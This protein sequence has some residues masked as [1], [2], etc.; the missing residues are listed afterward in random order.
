M[1]DDKENIDDLIAAA[2][3]LLSRLNLNPNESP[4]SLDDAIAEGIKL[5][6]NESN[7]KPQKK[8]ASKK[9][10]KSNPYVQA[11]EEI[12]SKLPEWKQHEIIR[13]EKDNDINNKYYSDF[14]HSVAVYGDS[15]S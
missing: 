6:K 2:D 3:K 12:L 10:V 14:V 15:L 13:M 9:K 4:Q 7:P 8:R 11:R 5:L 1:N